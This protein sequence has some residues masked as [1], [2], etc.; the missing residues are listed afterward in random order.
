MALRHRCA[1]LWVASWVAAIAPSA[2][3]QLL[4]PL[5]AQEPPK[6]APAPV[7]ARPAWRVKRASTIG[8]LDFAVRSSFS[9]VAGPAGASATGGALVGLDEA[10]SGSFGVFAYRYRFYGT[11]GGGG[12]G[13]EAEGAAD[14]LIGVRG[15]V[16]S[17]QGPF[18][19]GGVVSYALGNERIAFSFVA[20]AVEAGYEYVDR[21]VGFEAGA[22]GGYVPGGI[23]RWDAEGESRDP[24][25]APLFGVFG[26]LILQPAFLRFEW[27]RLWPSDAGAAMPLDTA[28]TSACVVLA[29]AFPLC[30]DV[31]S[32]AGG[33]HVAPSNAL[34]MATALYAG[35][36]LGVASGGTRYVDADR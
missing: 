2:A 25:Q 1:C 15:Y 13:L 9:Y 35:V 30:L 4:P 29:Q 7:P 33:V 3:G 32:F 14:L 6:L 8:W 34:G 24:G 12:G 10:N 11:V 27:R 19:R 16:T 18:A 20:P 21:T 26:T 28:S 5:D 36:S 22:I 23:G 31:R 17:K